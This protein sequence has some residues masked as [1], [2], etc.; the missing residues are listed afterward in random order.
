MLAAV[1]GSVGVIDR[2][3]ELD[4]EIAAEL[5][6]ISGATDR[7]GRLMRQ[8][9][10]FSQEHPVVWAFAS[11]NDL[12]LD[13]APML[14][15]LSG[16]R[17]TLAF[18]LDPD[19]D[20]VN[21]ERASFDQVLVNL[22]VNARDAMLPGGAVTIITRNV[23]LD[24][25]ARR[26]GAVGVGSHVVVEVSDTGEGIPAENLSR[27]FD[28]FFTTKPSGAGTGIGLTTVYAFVKRSGGHIE[29][30]SEVERGTRFSL[31]FPTSDAV[32]FVDREYP[33]DA[34]RRLETS[35]AFPTSVQYNPS[36]SA[37]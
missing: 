22:V 15:R 3:S 11:I 9:L 28:P 30:S 12:I 8:L 27:I 37:R 6:I 35:G 2:R 32:A 5:E 10:G 4:P 23:V 36:S 16:D 18:E 25:E 24:E 31:F 14:E 33:D 17:V 26:R 1:R 7:A 20:M 34:N 21:L 13:L 29:V 19:V